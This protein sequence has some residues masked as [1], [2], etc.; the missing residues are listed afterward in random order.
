MKFWSVWLSCKYPVIKAQASAAHAEGAVHLCLLGFIF[1]RFF[2]SGAAELL[3]RNKGFHHRDQQIIRQRCLAC[4][5]R[6]QDPDAVPFIEMQID[7][8]ILL[9]EH[10]T[11][12]LSPAQATVIK[13]RLPA[14]YELVL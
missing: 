5:I 13:E 9:C 1:D 8:I 4:R 6:S 7:V 2:L 3:F 12:R 10:H 14:R 11:D